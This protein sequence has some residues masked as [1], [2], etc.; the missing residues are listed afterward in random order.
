MAIARRKAEEAAALGRAEVAR[1]LDGAEPGGAGG[2]LRLRDLE[3]DGTA[4]SAAR[5]LG[6]ADLDA[7]YEAVGSG[8]L[9]PAEFLGR[10]DGAPAPGSGMSVS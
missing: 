1:A 5:R 6:Y 7:A 10:L 3:D 4:F 8:G 2:Q 9:A